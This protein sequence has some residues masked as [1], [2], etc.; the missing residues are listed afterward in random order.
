MKAFYTRSLPVL[1]FSKF[2]SALVPKLT[3][4]AIR[5]CSD[6]VVPVDGY[7]KYAKFAASRCYPIEADHVELI[8]K[9]ADFAR[10]F[11]EALNKETHEARYEAYLKNGANNVAMDTCVRNTYKSIGCLNSTKSIR[12]KYAQG[13][14]TD[15]VLF[16]SRF[17]ARMNA[18]GHTSC[19]YMISLFML[20]DFKK[21]GSA[22][23]PK[24]KQTINIYDT[25]EKMY[26]AVHTTCLADRLAQE[27]DKEHDRIQLKK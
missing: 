25:P 23:G 1:F 27:M 18:R 21:Y 8:N 4:I 7:A 20:R 26:Q 19:L 9:H 22:H 2:S 17:I 12:D 6:I 16:L 24:F 11:N 5:Q 14:A 3:T 15:E 10:E 13:K